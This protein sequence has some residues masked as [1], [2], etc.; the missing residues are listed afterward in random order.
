MKHCANLEEAAKDF[1]ILN[2]GIRIKNNEIFVGNLYRSLDQ[3]TESTFID[4]DKQV[5]INS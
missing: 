5:V 1:N 3:V 2:Q 4:L